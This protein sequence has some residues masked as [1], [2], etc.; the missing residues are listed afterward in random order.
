M[1]WLN[2]QG[3]WGEGPGAL[4]G[5]VEEK[6]LECQAQRLGL[7]PWEVPPELFPQTHSATAVMC[8]E[9]AHASGAEWVE[10]LDPVLQS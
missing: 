7:T 3:S 5:A 4:A 10:G 9:D 2:L 6:G 8:Q 1:L